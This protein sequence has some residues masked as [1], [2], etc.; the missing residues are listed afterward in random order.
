[1]EKFAVITGA[2]S[3]LGRAVSAALEGAGYK[4]ILTSKHNSRNQNIISAD[5]S[6]LITINRFI[7]SVK[8]LTNRVD[9][10]VNVAGIWHGKDEVFAGKNLTEFSEK[11]VIDTIMVG[12]VAPLLLAYHLLPLMPKKSHIIN[13]SGTFESGGK[14]WLPYFVSKRAIEDL[15]VGLAQDMAE[16]QIQVNGISPSDMATPAYKKYFPQYYNDG[17]DPKL[18]AG[19]IVK[20]A[21]NFDSNLSGKIFVMKKGEK[22]F[23]AFHY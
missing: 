22:P 14:G 10:L 11:T 1:M 17:I 18:I 2:G 4:L 5:L 21:A 13:I 19:Q 16:K 23:P 8:K 9:V 12:M 20:L 15:T 7:D 3:G 6:N